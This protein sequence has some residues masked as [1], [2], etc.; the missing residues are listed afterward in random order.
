MPAGEPSLL[1]LAI[2]LFRPLPHANC[3]VIR[4]SPWSGS[5]AGSPVA[6]YSRG[7]IACRPTSR[8][9][10]ATCMDC[11]KCWPIGIASASR[12]S[13]P[14]SAGKW[15]SRH[16]KHLYGDLQQASGDV[17]DVRAIDARRSPRGKRAIVPTVDG[18]RPPDESFPQRLDVSSHADRAVRGDSRETGRVYSGGGGPTAK[19]RHYL[20]FD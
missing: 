11:A 6:T 5:G 12:L 14:I 7:S 4:N 19:L 17:R 16:G 15:A 9:R 13:C 8:S 20:G 2:R 1:R 10:A 18:H 3:Y